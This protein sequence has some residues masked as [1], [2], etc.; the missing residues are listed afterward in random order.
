[1]RPELLSP[2][3]F[4]ADT[5]PHGWLFPRA[6]AVVHHGGAGTTAQGLRAGK[7][8]VIVPFVLDQPFWAARVRARGL[9]PEPIPRKKLTTERLAHAITLATADP[10]I[11]QRAAACGKAIRSENGLENAL[12]A[13]KHVLG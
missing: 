11:K 8:T 3:V 5:V 9:G 2:N 7:P 6:A 1:M 4:V 12:A 13:I 10:T